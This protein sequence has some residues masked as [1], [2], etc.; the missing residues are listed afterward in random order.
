LCRRLEGACAGKNVKAYFAKLRWPR[1]SAPLW[2]WYIIGG[3]Y[4]VSFFVVLHRLFRLESSSLRT[5]TLILI[6]FMMVAN[7]LWNFLFF[8]AQ[9][10]FASFISGSLA[11][12]FDL[13]LFICLINLDKT[14]AIALVPYLLYRIYAVW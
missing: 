8:R 5:A 12:I 2:F 13:A 3:A 11:P 7:A 4:Y 9:N 1:Y 10:L 14:A 6:L